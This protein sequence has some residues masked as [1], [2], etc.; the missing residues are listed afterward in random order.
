MASRWSESR[1]ETTKSDPNVRADICSRTISK[2]SPDEAWHLP[3]R[4]RVPGI[5]HRTGETQLHIRG[6]GVF[7]EIPVGDGSIP[8]TFLRAGTTTIMVSFTARFRF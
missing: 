4:I 7:V 8:G 2:D 1:V 6:F 3:R 5:R